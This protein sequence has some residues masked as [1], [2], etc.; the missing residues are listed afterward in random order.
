[1]RNACRRSPRPAS[2]STCANSGVTVRLTLLAAVALASAVSAAELSP[3]LIPV[4][5]VRA[6]ALR[7]TFSEGRAGH[8]H[9]AIDIAAARGA[10]V[11]A[12]ADGVL[13]K[14]FTSVPGGLTIYQFDSERRHA[15][16]YAHLDR[17]AGG[18][19]EGMALRRGDV[20]GYVGSTGNAS[21]A[22]PHLHF[23]VFVL[24]PEKQWWKGEAIDPFAALGGVAAAK[25]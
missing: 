8:R 10:R 24:G 11:V 17:Y 23:A 5:G 6:E 19:K 1:M 25:P 9:E 2:W 12:V 22:A 16:Y 7:D 20:I 13:A 18:M 14:L 4:E 21:A 3:L 15:F